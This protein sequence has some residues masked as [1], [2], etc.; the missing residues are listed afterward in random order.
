LSW[1]R[2]EAG[3]QPKAPPYRGWESEPPTLPGHILGFSAIPARPE[4]YTVE[5]PIPP[6]LSRGKTNVVIKFQSHPGN[7]A[8][9]L[10]DLRILNK[11]VQ[12]FVFAAVGFNVKARM[13]PYSFASIPESGSYLTKVKERLIN[14][15]RPFNHELAKDHSPQVQQGGDG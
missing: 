11:L 13:P 1:F 8:G 6:E 15:P 9:G 3:L 4:F 2:R 12:G 10:F 5:T 14:Q 7:T